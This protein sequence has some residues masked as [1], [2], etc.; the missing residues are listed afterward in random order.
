MRVGSSTPLQRVG[1]RVQLGARRVLRPLR[2]H[3]AVCA[4]PESKTDKTTTDKRLQLVE[5][6]KERM[7][8]RGIDKVRVCQTLATCNLTALGQATARQILRVWRDKGVDGDPQQLRKVRCLPAGL[9][10]SC[11]HRRCWPSSRANLLHK[12]AP[13]SWWTTRCAT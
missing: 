13:S 12:R 5:Q 3:H 2:H 6:A 4:N 1:G 11:V 8:K 7:K 9:Q 10:R